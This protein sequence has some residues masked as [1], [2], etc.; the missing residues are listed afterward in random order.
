M[1]SVK[2][3]VSSL[4]NIESNLC[5]LDYESQNFDDTEVSNKP[6]YTFPNYS[7]LTIHDPENINIP[8]AVNDKVDNDVFEKERSR[9]PI[10]EYDITRVSSRNAKKGSKGPYK[11]GE[12]RQIILSYGMGKSNGTK[13]DL[14]NT[15]RSFHT[16]RT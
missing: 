1:E 13:K 4:R 2:K 12:L 15:I 5:S 10:I 11:T 8:M 14:V 7:I 6:M 9:R 16:S 3:I